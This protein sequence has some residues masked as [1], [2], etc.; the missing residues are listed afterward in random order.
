MTA[1]LF[2]KIDQITV[3]LTLLIVYLL[4]KFDEQSCNISSLEHVNYFELIGY[5]GHFVFQN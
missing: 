4:R 1:I 3:R 2:S 5:G